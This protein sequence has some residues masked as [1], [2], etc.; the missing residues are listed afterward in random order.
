MNK[1]TG[2]VQEAAFKSI[3]KDVTIWNLAKIAMREAIEIG[4]DT[5]IDDFVFIMGGKRTVFGSFVHIASFSSIT[6][7]G[8]F[9]IEDFSG[10][11]AGVRAFTGDDDYSKGENLCNPTIDPPFRK[12]FRSFIH[13]K[14]HVI[15]GANTV[16]LPGVVIGEGVAVGANSLI[17]KDCEPWTVYAGT[18]ARIIKSRPRERI[19]ELEQELRRTYY[20]NNGAYIPKSERMTATPQ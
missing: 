15:I 14:K 10:F 11:S 7:G 18:P 20:D 4:D 1:L 5:M 12:P 3:G 9:I 6:G 17:K 13:I 8:E 2:S 16:I 19:I